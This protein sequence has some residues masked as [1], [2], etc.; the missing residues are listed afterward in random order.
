LLLAITLAVGAPALAAAG[1]GPTR[2]TVSGAI[3]LLTPDASLGEANVEVLAFPQGGEVSA[4]AETVTSTGRYELQ[5]DIELNTSYFVLVTYE[6]IQYLSNPLVLSPD[7]PTVS[8][9]FEVYA[10]TA[11]AP[12]LRIETTTVTL[13]AID[14]ERAELTFIR[15]DAIALDEPLI[16]VGAEDGIT[17]RLPVPENTT[18]AGGMEADDEDYRFDGGTVAVATPLRPGVTSVVTR[19]TVRYE[20]DKD[21]YRLRITAPVNTDRMAIRVPQRFLREVRPVGDDATLGADEAFESGS[22]SEPLTVIE[23]TSPATPG[24]GLIADL[25]GLSGI[26]RNSHPLT[27]GAGA[28]VGALLALL[29]VSGAAVGLQRIRGR[30]A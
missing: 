24:Q 21:E 2:G 23:R 6:D 5:L 9:D 17:L 28:V 13:L 20:A 15:E 26:E 16:Y 29:V 11:T 12:E 1:D 3:R 18:D 4:V 8:A 27:S 22:G 30:T 7:A 14:R 19:Y 10:T 25:R